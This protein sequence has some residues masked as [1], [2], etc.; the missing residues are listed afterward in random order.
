MCQKTGTILMLFVVGPVS[1]S[2]MGN[3]GII[4]SDSNAMSLADGRL[5]STGIDM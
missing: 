3:A 2:V 1:T 4:P 5:P